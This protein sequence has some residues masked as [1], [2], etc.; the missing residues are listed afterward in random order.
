M[1]RTLDN[2]S[3]M[4]WLG[5][6]LAVH[7]C[8]QP[9]HTYTAMIWALLVRSRL[10]N[11]PSPTVVPQA[12]HIGRKGDNPKALVRIIGI[13]LYAALRYAISLHLNLYGLCLMQQ[14]TVSAYDAIVHWP[15]SA[16]MILSQ[17]TCWIPSAVTSV[18]ISKLKL[19][20]YYS[21]TIYN[22]I[23]TVKANLLRF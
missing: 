18:L 21:K 4:L 15:N 22:A 19:G 12:A 23:R 5:D 9:I 7:P 13:S 17:E 8:I 11:A 10:T 6:Q 20:T 16:F 2:F 3:F 1:S 14:T